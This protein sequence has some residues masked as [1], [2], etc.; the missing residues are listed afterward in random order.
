MLTLFPCV[1]PLWHLLLLLQMYT[2]AINACTLYNPP[3]MRRA[4][5]VYAQLQRHDVEPDDLLYGNLI[6]LAGRSRQL[7]VAFD[8]VQDMRE[9]G[10]RPGM[11]TCS[12]LIYACISNGNLPAARKVYDTLQARSVVPHISQYNALMEQYAL[13][14]RLGTVVSLLGQ[15]VEAGVKTNANTFR[16][17]V[18]AAQRADQAELAFELYQVAKARGYLRRVRHAGMGRRGGVAGAAG[19]LQGAVGCRQGTGRAF[20]V[21]YACDWNQIGHLSG[22]PAPPPLGWRCACL[23]ILAATAPWVMAALLTP[24]PCTCT[25]CLQDN[26]RNVQSMMHGLLK[27]C[28]NRIRE[29]WRPGGYP[30]A[31]HA[32]APRSHINL[33]SQEAE[34]VL[35]LVD[36]SSRR[37]RTFLENAD[38]INWSALALAT[39]REFTTAGFKPTLEVL[40]KLLMCLRLP[41]ASSAP[42]RIAGTGASGGAALSS[43]GGGSSGSSGGSGSGFTPLSPGAA[44]AADAAVARSQELREMAREQESVGRLAGGY[45]MPYDKRALDIVGEA[46]NAGLLPGLKVRGPGFY[47]VLCLPGFKQGGEGFLLWGCVWTCLHSGGGHPSVGY[48]PLAL[49]HILDSHTIITTCVM[50][51]D[52][53]HAV[54][55][56]GPVTGVTRCR[57]TRHWTL[58]CAP[59]RP[60]SARHGRMHC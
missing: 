16:I 54:P 43:S 7:D 22:L 17:L 38:T 58:T 45:E 18:L 25:S 49:V 15:M 40:D 14:F 39:Y 42:S 32:A 56:C 55:V 5:D 20:L 21:L 10:L 9:G 19:R 3:D 47:G 24:K 60:L 12:A 33:R 1:V 36:K 37:Q 11:A 2:A 4:L 35:S 13:R 52:T 51:P 28:F 41:L 8:L 48:G 59:S 44:T 29:A 6:A 26:E 27:L 50:C 34:Q 23:C 57:W 46:I 53:H 30:P 31:A